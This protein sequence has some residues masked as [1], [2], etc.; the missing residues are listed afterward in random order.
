[1]IKSEEITKIGQLVKPH[2]IKG[3]ITATL[4]Y[5]I[6]LTEL[7]CIV[8]NVDGIFVPFFI[9]AVRPK[10]SETVILSVDGISSDSEAKQ[11][12]GTDYYALN[13]DLDFS[14]EPDGE[15]G[16]V[17]DFVGYTVTGPDGSVIGRI[18]DYDDS[19]SNVLFIVRRPGGSITYIPVAEEF[20][21]AIDS[22]GKNIV[23]SLPEGLIE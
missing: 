12:C 11:L 2:G 17:S 1:M 18:E 8:V 16:Y 13:T 9:N 3:E 23:M 14:D 15:G 20:I 10:S 7:K 5:D 22:T 21:D 4:D 6:D 19:T